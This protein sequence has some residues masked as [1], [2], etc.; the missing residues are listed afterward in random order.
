MGDVCEV[1]GF[2]LASLAPLAD[3]LL[4]ECWSDLICVDSALQPPCCQLCT[5]GAR[6]SCC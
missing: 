2:V 3:R 5:C 4:R 6:P 1:T